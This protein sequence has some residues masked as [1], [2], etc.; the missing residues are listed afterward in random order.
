MGKKCKQKNE[1]NQKTLKES[2]G[3]TIKWVKQTVQELRIEREATR[4]Q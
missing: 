2:Q 1:R 3:K 4:K